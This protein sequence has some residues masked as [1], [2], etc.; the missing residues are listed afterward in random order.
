MHDA[1]HFDSEQHECDVSPVHNTSH[2][3]SEQHECDVP[4][5][6]IHHILIVNSMSEMFLCA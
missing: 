4:L 6:T 2:F 5:C 1:S 3:D